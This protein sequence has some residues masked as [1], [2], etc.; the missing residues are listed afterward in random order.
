MRRQITLDIGLV[1]PKIHIIDNMLLGTSEY[2]IKIRGVEKGRGDVSAATDQASVIAT[3]F[4]E[5]IKQHASELNENPPT[6]CQ[7]QHLP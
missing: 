3:H 6:S 2:S 5:I 7:S 1:T 4:T